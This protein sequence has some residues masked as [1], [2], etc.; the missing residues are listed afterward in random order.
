[1]PR[2]PKDPAK[3]TAP[4]GRKVP[5]K[6]AAPAAEEVI[7]VTIDTSKLMLPDLKLISRLRRGALNDEDAMDLLERCVVGGIEHIPLPML[8][9]VLAA[10]FDAVYRNK[11][12]ETDQGN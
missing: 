6:A 8:S 11:N 4:R 2:P 3:S 1:M 10:L 9:D 7:N 5:A 12:P